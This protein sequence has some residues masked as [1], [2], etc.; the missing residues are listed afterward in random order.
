MK[1]TKTMKYEIAYDKTVYDILS[2]IQYEIRRVKNRAVTMAW[3]WLNFSFGYKER[4]G[5]YP[6]PKDLLGKGLKADIYAYTKEL[7]PFVYSMTVDAASQEAVSK[8][9]EMKADIL[10]GDVAIPEYKKGGSFPCRASQIGKLTK[11]TSK[12]YHAELALLSRE[13]AKDR[14]LTTRFPVVLR[15]G[16]GANDIL[17]RIIEG[18]YKLCD[19]RISKRK[20]KFYIDVA[21]QHEV[22]APVRDEARVMG[23]DLGIANAVYMA[24]NFDKFLF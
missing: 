11:E 10:R 23:V 16:K 5:E 12:K 2:E 3:D 18:E 1:I 8:L 20:K 9:E 15:T 6:K 4:Y 22:T 14:G 24:F 19:S 7:A 17:D 13:G 21:Y